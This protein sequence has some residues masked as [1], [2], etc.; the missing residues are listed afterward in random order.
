MS[1][2]NRKRSFGGRHTTARRPRYGGARPG[3]QASGKQYIDPARFVR[4][5]RVQEV[6]EYIPTHHFKDFALHEL[7]IHNIN[8]K[9]YTAP[10]KI[11]DLAIP[12]GL[13]GKDVLGIANTG[14]G[15]TTAF[16]VPLLQKLLLNPKAQALIIAPTRELAGQINQEVHDLILG[17]R[18]RSVVLIGGTAINPQTRQLK[19]RP[20]I[21]IGTPGR[22]IDHVKQGNLRLGFFHTVVLDEVDRMVDMGF[23]Q[24]IRYILGQVPEE[25]QSL[26]FSA[27][28]DQKVEGLTH[29]FLREP[30]VISVKTGDTSDNV[31]QSVV[32]HGDTA[33]KIAKLYALL[34]RDM[35][36][37][38]LIFGETKRE[39]ERLSKQLS[40]NGYKAGALHG[41][42]SQSQRQRALDQFRKNDLNILVATDVAARGIDIVDISHVI[43]FSTPQT[44]DDY[45]HRIGRV[46]RAGRIGHAFTFV[47]APKQPQ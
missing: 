42:K 43:N 28:M 33:D 27:T 46:G 17:S 44:Y 36:K 24:D 47:T 13:E 37:K 20:Q 4:A 10:T 38:T 25:R 3:R 7:L 30:T 19:A 11:Q 23:I 12:A 21:V 16:A 15:K 40:T 8:K 9:G 5:A 29:S 39:V 34:D 35:V 22:I 45:I 14:T 41:G 31:E 18:L 2:F 1:Q 26:F 32:H 6:E